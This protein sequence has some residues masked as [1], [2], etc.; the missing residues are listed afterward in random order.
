VNADI[1]EAQ[2]RLLETWTDKDGKE[3]PGFLTAFLDDY[4]AAKERARTA[5]L[6]D[7]GLGPLYNPN[8]YP[9]LGEISQ[10]FGIDRRWVAL[11]V[12]EGL[13]PE[14]RE[15]AAEELRADLRNAAETI[16]DSLAQ[17]LSELIN[18]AKEVL[19]VKPGEKPKIVKESLIGNVL[20]FCE[21]FQ[22]RN[23]QGDE[24]L[25]ALVNEAKA[26]LTGVDPEK[27]RKFAHIRSHAAEKFAELSGKIDSL[28]TTRKSRHF[29]L[30][31]DAEPVA[32]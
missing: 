23:T 27:C 28:I 8:D 19:E 4:S 6:L 16:K 30:T 17:G 24:Q 25:A 11:G 9:G 26:A 21:V 18:H 5:P 29:D 3:H 14:L 22:L 10:G 2:R 20:Q 12:P 13:P 32:A 15:Q 1:A 7:G 31:P